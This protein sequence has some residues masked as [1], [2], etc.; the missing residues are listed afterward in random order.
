MTGK[1]P[2]LKEIAEL[3][4]VTPTTVSLALRKHPRISESTRKRVSE[5]AEKLG[6]RQDAHLSHLMR[7][8]RVPA[9]RKEFPVMAL[10]SD[11]PKRMDAEK[12]P[13]S[14]WTGFSQQATALGYVPQEF[15][16]SNENLSPKRLNGILKARGIRGVLFAALNE[17]AYVTKMD[18]SRL[19]C[20]TIGNVI[21]EPALSRATSDKFSNTVLLCERMWSMGYRRIGL[22]IPKSQEIR[23]EDTFLGG[24]LTFQFRH[25][26]EQWSAP[27]A[28]E[29]EWDQAAILNWVCENRPDA[30]IAAYPGLR[31][32]LSEHLDIKNQ[33]FVGLISHHGDSQSP[34]IAQRHDRVAAAA[35]NI[36]DAQLG[37]NELGILPN[38]TIQLVR[39]SWIEAGSKPV[40]GEPK[41]TS[42][43][44][45]RRT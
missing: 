43:K 6:Y 41:A 9:H 10:V 26:H 42:Q 44:K 40:E 23:V 7:H 5:I 21:R 12:G 17:P 8:L 13:F 4:K 19:A 15:S 20:A 33:P 22:V 31:Q 36:V 45:D 35:V 1:R 27:L 32:Y 39:G 18:L 29:G 34:G 38:A 2:T 14:S 30:V 11:A 25:S 16:V 3:A 37:R 28:Y 24:Y